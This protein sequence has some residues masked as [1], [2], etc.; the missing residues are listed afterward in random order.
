MELETSTG[1]STQE[2]EEEPFVKCPWTRDDR[3]RFLL[4][5]R[6]RRRRRK[7]EDMLIA[8]WTRRK[9]SRINTVDAT[10]CML[11]VLLL[12]KVKK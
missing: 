1:R 9:R 7:G 5:I 2:D 10:V 3:W 4:A 11:I 6:A 12:L 8:W